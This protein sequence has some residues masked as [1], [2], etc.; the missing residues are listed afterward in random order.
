M[1]Q[2]SPITN[3]EAI[4]RV[5]EIVDKMVKHEFSEREKQIGRMVEVLKN[6][7]KEFIDSSTRE[8]KI[9]DYKIL[10]DESV[11]KLSDQ[12]IFNSKCGYVLHGSPYESEYSEWY[13]NQAMVK[14][15][16]S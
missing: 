5:Q 15:E 16:K 10:T 9:V 7:N 11:Q 1:N 6:A 14:Y 2:F 3:E 8:R 12:I 4:I 13:I